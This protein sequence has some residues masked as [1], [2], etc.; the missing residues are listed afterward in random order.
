M[1][2]IHYTA[3]DSDESALYRLSMPEYE[4]SCHYLIGGNGR[5][6]RMVDEKMRAWHAG[7]GSWGGRGD[8]NSRSIGIEVSNSGTEPYAA[9]QMEALEELLKDI[10]SRWSIPPEGVI[11]HSDLAVGRK[12]DPGP[13]FDWR[14][15]ALSGLSV[16]PDT[17][18]RRTACAIGFVESA[19]RFGYELPEGPGDR[20][21]SNLLDAFRLRFR[22]WARGPLGDQDVGAIENLAARWPCRQQK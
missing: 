10:M 19:Q 17:R 22:P 21:L 9:V 14:R 5:V 1:I 15:L 13:K 11:G 8:V 20:A 12:A 18:H 3:M 2:V 4:V 16:W 6:Y 7:L